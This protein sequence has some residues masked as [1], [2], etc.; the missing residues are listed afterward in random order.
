MTR[1]QS[2]NLSAIIFLYP[3]ILYR[4][5]Y[6]F[7]VIKKFVYLLHDLIFDFPKKL[8]LIK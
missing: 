8:N 4:S 5:K 2:S 1:Q 7:E 3:R 6:L